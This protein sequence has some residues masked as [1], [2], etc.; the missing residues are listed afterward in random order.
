MVGALIL[1]LLIIPTRGSFETGVRR[2]ISSAADGAYTVATADIDGDGDLDVL[3]A[4]MYDDTIAWYENMDGA[5][6]FSSRAVIS[7]DADG[8]T[9]VF[10]VDIDGDGD[11]D[12]VSSSAYDGTV[13]WYENVNG[14]GTFGEP[15]VITRE[16]SG[17]NSVVAADVDGDGDM[18]VLSASS[19]DNKIAWY[20]N[21]NGAG[22]FSG[23]LLIT[24]L[25]DGATSVYAADLDGDGDI[26]V[27]SSS[28]TGNKIA[29]Y[30]NLNG[31]G[32]F[33][34]QVVIST[35][36]GV[37]HS[38]FAADVDGDGDLDVL[39]ASASDG[40][41]AWYE[42]TDG[43]GTFGT[44]RV[45]TTLAAYAQSVTA[46][47]LDGDGDLDVL[48]ASM[49]DDK[50]AWYENLNGVGTFGPQIVITTG[51]AGAR[52][53]AT[54]DLDG[55]GDVDVLSSSLT[56]DTIAWYENVGSPPT[57][58][59]TSPVT[60]S[61]SDSGDA[62]GTMA[63]VAD[64]DGSTQTGGGDVES[65]DGSTAGAVVA[66]LIILVIAAVAL[67]VLHRRR[68]NAAVSTATATVES[69]PS[70]TPRYPLPASGRIRAA[71][72][73][74]V[75]SG[76]IRSRG[77]SASQVQRDPA[78]ERGA[79]F[80]GR[81]SAPSVSHIP[82]HMQTNGHP[83]SR[84][85]SASTPRRSARSSQRLPA[86]LAYA[87]LPVRPP[88]RTPAD[89]PPSLTQYL[90]HAEL[91]KKQPLGSGASGVV[92]RGTWRNLDVAIKELREVNNSLLQEEAARLSG[93]RPHKHIVMMYGVTKDPPALVLEFCSGGSLDVALYGPN[94]LPFG[95]DRLL[96]IA[97]GCALG[98]EHMHAEHL[99]HRDVAARNVLLD[100]YG[101][102]KLTDFGMARASAFAERATLSTALP[103]KWAAPEQIEESLV[104]TASDVFSFGCL[105]WEIFE[106]SPPWQTVSSIDAAKA[107]LAGRRM[108]PTAAPPAICLLMGQCWAHDRRARPAAASIVVSLQPPSRPQYVVL[109]SV[110]PIPQ[111][112]QAYEETNVGLFRR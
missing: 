56:D 48:S 63:V 83:R 49:S 103:I 25:V 69:F 99:V 14:L 1:G 91:V 77:P 23:Q 94:P 106:R 97:R 39:S 95:E 11:V 72:T 45:I 6:S 33:G 93:L 102:P 16:A 66:V 82:S 24:D 89:S 12:V 92:Y 50:V 100:E 22:S 18:D 73:R 31:A 75:R 32:T 3:S 85:T 96:L 109:P 61:G 41:I 65:D 38:V 78:G 44:Q 36:A 37:A 107:V 53:V 29:W 46:G 54:A 35:Q 62:S 58:P 64:V 79:T 76:S 98:L 21:L 17:A 80:S 13:A 19:P 111:A 87:R 57:P 7:N 47:D 42:N 27:L 108:T 9:S 70:T 51:A 112:P 104:S 68:L 5:G 81:P 26:D 74:S 43:A 20:K 67:Y 34:G 8:A 52:C 88:P 110:A 86:P 90:P 101:S 28:A 71:E 15:Q 60:V 4:S 55:D 10:G 40:K 84:S 59:P 30:E 2:V 105:L